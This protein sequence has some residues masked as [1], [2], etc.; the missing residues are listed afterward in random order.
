M[1][2]V[3]DYYPFTHEV[4]D[5]AWKV[6]LLYEAG[7]ALAADALRQ[8]YIDRFKRRDYHFNVEAFNYCC[9]TP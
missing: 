9:R 1:K 6:W 5:A 4:D 7:A 3:I 8:R 2:K